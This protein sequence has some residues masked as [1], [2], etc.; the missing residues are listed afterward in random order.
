MK[1]TMTP[2]EWIMMNALWEKSPATLSEVIRMVGSRAAWNYK[3]Y[4][5]YMLILERKGF[6]AADKR[7][8]D[9]FY[10][11]IVSKEAC[12]A[13][14]KNSILGKMEGDAVKMLIA[15][16]VQDSDLTPDACRDLQGLLDELLKKEER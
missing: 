13:Q 4:Q 6:I 8:R 5:S 12:V 16:M 14:E 15:G 3:T 11:P 1:D 10:Y 2:N 9:K 7:G